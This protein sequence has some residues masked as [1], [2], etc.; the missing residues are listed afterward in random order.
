[1][2]PHYVVIAKRANHRCEYCQAPEIVFTA[3]TYQ[4]RHKITYR[5]GSKQIPQ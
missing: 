3:N 4:T 2:N 1:M 5:K